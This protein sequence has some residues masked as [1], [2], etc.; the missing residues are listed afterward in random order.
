M[1]KCLLF[2][3]V[4]HHTVDIRSLFELRMFMFFV[5]SK[6][7]TTTVKPISDDGSELYLRRIK[8]EGMERP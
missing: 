3:F 2:N 6:K 4:A 1:I 8:A 7:K 5:S